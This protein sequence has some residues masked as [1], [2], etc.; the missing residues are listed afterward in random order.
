MST[1]DIDRGWARIRRELA[2]ANKLEVAVGI[3]EGSKNADGY[4]IAEYAAA[5][6]YGTENIPDRPFMRT[7][8]DENRPDIERDMQAQYGA[9]CS[10]ERTARQALT[11]IGMRHVE[12]TK[13]TITNRDFLPR[14]ADSTVKAKKGST[15]TLVDT[16]AMVNAVQISVRPKE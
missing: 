12:R 16:S 8:F 9:V 13:N 15:K 3:L 14:L 6:E 11:V 5:N 2:K 4:A 7:T 1:K 10:G